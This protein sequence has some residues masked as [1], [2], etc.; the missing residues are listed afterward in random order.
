MG[1]PDSFKLTEYSESSGQPAVRFRRLYKM[2][3]NSVCPPLVAT[4][5]S[6]MLDHASWGKEGATRWSQLGRSAALNLALSSVAPGPRQEIQKALHASWHSW[7][8]LHTEAHAE[9]HTE[10]G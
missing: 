3:G 4:L 7:Q 5:A 10:D 1:F 9:D 6:A 8:A 2:F